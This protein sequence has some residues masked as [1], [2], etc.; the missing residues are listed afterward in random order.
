[1]LPDIHRRIVYAKYILERA[2][3]IVAENNE[4]SISI[5]LLLQHDAI[6]LLMLGVLDHLQLPIKNKREFMDFWTEIKQAGLPEAPDLVA[7]QS[8]NKLRVGLKHNGNLPNPVQVRELLPRTR[9]FF[10]N[11]LKT[12]CAISYEDVSLID[13]VQ[14]EE[15][16]TVLADSRQKFLSGE[17][18]QSLIKLK[19]ALH[20]LEHP[21]GKLL[22]LLRAP[23]KPSLPSEVQRAAGQYLDQLHTFFEQTASRTN[24]L[25][26]G[27]DPIR[28]TKFVGSTPSLVW[29]FAGTYQAQIWR[30]YAEMKIEEYEELATFLIDY[31]LRVQ[32]A[33]IPDVIGNARK[34]I[35]VAAQGAS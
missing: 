19:V 16:R 28:Y 24:A 12:Y 14:D 32:N 3:Q 25:M 35:A 2:S 8:L 34:Q 10:E 21:E 33:Y 17:V 13:L 22:P 11:V 30:S 20:K 26:L 9:G 29:T 5:A 27:I 1:M 6:E 7:M 4:M 18:D 15:V 31:A 23:K